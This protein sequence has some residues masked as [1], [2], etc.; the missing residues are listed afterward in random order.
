M[1]WSNWANYV[2]RYQYSQKFSYKDLKEIWSHLSR[3]KFANDEKDGV[4]KVK[5]IAVLKTH[6]A[7]TFSYTLA[8]Y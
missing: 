4:E 2:R 5:V 3:A 8:P 6:I 1:W 7:T